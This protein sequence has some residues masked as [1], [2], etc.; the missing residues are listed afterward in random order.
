MLRRAAFRQLRYWVRS[1]SDIG[2][3]DYHGFDSTGHILQRFD[4]EFDKWGSSRP[5]S[6]RRTV[7]CEGTY[8]EKRRGIQSLRPVALLNLSPSYFAALPLRVFFNSRPH[9]TKAEEIGRLVRDPQMY[10]KFSEYCI[11]S[12]NIGEKEQEELFHFI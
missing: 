5:R 3:D 7:R 11:E 1:C 6:Q 4:F 8:W 2:F 9:H 12:S 10:L